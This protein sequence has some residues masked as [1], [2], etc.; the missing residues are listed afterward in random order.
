MTCF[1][2]YPLGFLTKKVCVNVQNSSLSKV[3]SCRGL[4]KWALTAFSCT[5]WGWW[6]WWWLGY[7]LRWSRV[8]ECL[9]WSSIN[10]PQPHATMHALVKCNLTHRLE[11]IY[12]PP[13]TCGIAWLF[14]NEKSLE[15]T[16][17]HYLHLLTLNTHIDSMSNHCPLLMSVCVWP[18]WQRRWDGLL[19]CKYF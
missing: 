2:F 9:R 15:H 17:T 13:L 18:K 5:W 7:L 19:L 4:W 12:P 14:M 6:W 1:T 8:S 3:V 16:Y 11:Q 10:V